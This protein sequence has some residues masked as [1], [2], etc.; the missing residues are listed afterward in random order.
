MLN[1][2][3]K[4][5]SGAPVKW[6]FNKSGVKQANKVG[7]R[8]ATAQEK[9]LTSQGSLPQSTMQKKETK[10]SKPTDVLKKYD[11]NCH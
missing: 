4:D 1:N 2:L 9:D 3:S 5:K 11:N 8:L 6:K 10:N 7:K